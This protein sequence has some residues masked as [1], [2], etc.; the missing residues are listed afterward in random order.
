VS[1]LAKLDALVDALAEAETRRE[2]ARRLAAA[3]C[4]EELLLFARDPE[5]GALMPAPGMAKTLRGGPL[6]RAFLTSCATPGSRRGEV[7]L[8]ISTRKPA[9]ALSRADAVA[10]AVGGTPDEAGMRFLERRM[11]ILGSLFR[12]QQARARQEIDARLAREA[13]ESARSLMAALESAR[14]QAADLNVRLTEESKRKDEFLAML[15]HELRNPLAPLVNSVELLRR[16]AG[17]AEPAVTRRSLDVMSRQL[18]H[19]ARLVNDLLDVSRVSRGA[20]ELQRELLSLE[21]VLQLARE[22]AAP[23]IESKGHRLEVRAPERPVRVQG[24]R[25]RLV[26]IFGN[27]LNN[28]AKFTPPGGDIAL[29]LSS[30]GG[31]A[32]VAVRDNGLGIPADMIEPIFQ[33]FSQA[34]STLARSE[35]GLGIGLTLARTLARL[36]GGTVEARSE[37]LGMGSEFV[38]TLPEAAA[39]TERPELAAELGSAPAPRRRVRVLL[40]EDNAD[41]A[42]SMAE[43]LRHM[44]AEV[45]AAEDGPRALA[46]APAFNPH[47]VLL[48]IGLPGMSGY[49]VASRLRPSLAAGARLIALTGYGAPEDE[50]RARAAGFD[51][52]LVKPASPQALETVLSLS[53]A[54]LPNELPSSAWPSAPL[55]VGSP[56][57]PGS[58]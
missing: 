19:M 35:G 34:H 22:T 5:V 47:L 48:D 38:V 39:S 13:A 52:H 49:E 29:E 15:A 28:A 31:Q 17:R 37:G 32:R 41:S 23:A 42:A 53:A 33:L 1:D 6:W 24:D 51:E 56:S 36:H 26:Q 12:A 3:L 55:G 7:D 21:E 25:A 43:L 40:V 30:E 11:G 27:L 20:I 50:A 10:V 46:Q 2:A 18:S 54:A 14:S 44:G 57:A 16:V 9:W 45:L 58:R 4:C 8:P